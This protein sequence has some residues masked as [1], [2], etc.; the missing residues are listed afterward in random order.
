MQV[1]KLIKQNKCAQLS[2]A[3]KSGSRTAVWSYIIKQ[4]KKVAVCQAISVFI[5]KEPKAIN[6]RIWNT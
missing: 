6:Y 4:N 5:L 1:K 2:Q 3:A